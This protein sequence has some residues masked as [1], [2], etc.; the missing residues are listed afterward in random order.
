LVV[1]SQVKPGVEIELIAYNHLLS[2]SSNRVRF[3]EGNHKRYNIFSGPKTFTIFVKILA[4]SNTLF[5][6]PKFMQR[7]ILM[8]CENIITN[9]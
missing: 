7:V 9:H 8:I 5:D 6:A 4:A 1:L 2:N 3:C